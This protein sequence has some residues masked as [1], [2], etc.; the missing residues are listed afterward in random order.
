MIRNSMVN[1]GTATALEE[2]RIPKPDG[3][4]NGDDFKLLGADGHT[5]PPSKEVPTTFMANLDK[6]G[7]EEVTLRRSTLW[8]IGTGLVLATVLFS[9]GGS[10]ISW[11]RDDESQRL[12]IQ[13]VQNELKSIKENQ[14]KMM[15]LIEAERTERITQAIQNAKQEGYKLGVLDNSTGHAAEP[16]K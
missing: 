1:L 9:Y 14:D 5:L 10:A 16:K 15:L 6:K 13:Q 2:E 11:V 7:S 8:F 12:Q 3:P 4:V